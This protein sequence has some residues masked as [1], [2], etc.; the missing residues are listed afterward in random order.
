MDENDSR[1]QKDF[2]D[3]NSVD[4]DNTDQQGR[5]HCMQLKETKADITTM[6]EYLKFDFQPNW[7]KNKEY[8]DASFEERYERHMR[9]E[10]RLP[11]R[12][13]LNTKYFI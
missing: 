10:H 4:D 3:S 11:L 2:D 5:E 12:V 9:N 13:Y 1:R 7:M 8:W 6:D